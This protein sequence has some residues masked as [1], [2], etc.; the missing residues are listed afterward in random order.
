M[1]NL[2]LFMAAAIMA[3]GLA[4]AA[5]LKALVPRGAGFESS[6]RNEGS[7]DL[8]ELKYH[9]GPVLSGDITVHIIWYGDWKPNSKQ[10]IKDFLLSISDSRAQTPSVSEWW[11]TVQLYTDQTG[12]NI[13]K[14][15]ILGTEKD[16][17]YSEGKILTRLTVQTVIKNAVSA[18]SNPLPVDS[19]NGVYLVLT[20]DDVSMQDFCRAVCGFHYFTFPSIVGSTLPYAWVGNSG[21]QCAD[22]CAFPFAVPSYVAKTGFKPFVAPN[23]DIGVEGMISVIG[24]ELAELSSNPLVNAWY[25]GDDP[26]SPT[27]I[28]DLCVGVY[29]SGGGGGYTGQVMNDK[30][31]ATYNLNSIRRKFLVQWIWSPVLNACYGPNAVDT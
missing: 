8:V 31:G 22:V 7:S 12:K 11:K 30:A 3:A 24:H 13:S 14:T 2:G 16:D 29:G 17:L 15:L 23:G 1:R 5:Q 4:E 26:T 6:K 18:V 19:K 21:R 25:A 27:E 20:S 9:M 28:A 10:I